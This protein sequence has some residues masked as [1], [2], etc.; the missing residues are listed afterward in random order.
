MH[1]IYLLKIDIKCYLHK[2]NHKRCTF[3]VSLSRFKIGI[4]KVASRLVTLSG[5]YI[6]CQLYASQGSWVNGFLNYDDCEGEKLVK[7]PTLSWFQKK[8]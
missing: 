8:N 3:E 2:Q 5:K 4:S 1:Y 6:V 7:T